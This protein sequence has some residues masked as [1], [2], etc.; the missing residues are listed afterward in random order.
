MRHREP[1]RV[2][3]VGGEARIFN[4]ARELPREGFIRRL[5][6]GALL[7]Q[8]REH[9]HRFLLYEIQAELVI[10]ERHAADVDPLALVLLFF[11][12]EQVSVELRLQPLVGVVYAQLFERVVLEEL[13]PVDVQ[14]AYRRPLRN[15]VRVRGEARVDSRDEPVEE[16]RVHRLCQRVATLLRPLRPKLRRHPLAPRKLHHPRAEG[17]AQRV[18]PDAQEPRRGGRRFR[19]LPR[20][21]AARVVLPVQFPIDEFDVAQPQHRGDDPENLPLRHRVDAHRVQ[22]VAQHVALAFI[23]HAVDV[24]DAGLGEVLKLERIARDGELG[25]FLVVR[26]RAEAVED[27]VGAFA[28][29]GRHD[30]AFLEQVG[31]YPRAYHRAVDAE[32]DVDELAEPRAVVVSLRLCVAEGF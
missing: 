26:A 24:H 12:L 19:S 7:V 18:G 5:G 31:A 25:S 27:V 30:A 9:A 22:R 13:E 20:R 1:R 16:R 23:V 11:Q 6:K 14:Y 2:P 28:V 4:L 3:L 17:V 32:V 10:L 29:C 15:P 21:H 8:Q